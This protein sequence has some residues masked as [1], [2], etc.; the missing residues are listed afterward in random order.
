MFLASSEN[1]KVQA[2]LKSTGL[3]FNIAKKPLFVGTKN[4]DGIIEYGDSPYF[5]L[6]NE[7]SG[8]VI[9]SVKSGYTVTQNEEI[10]SMVVEGIKQFGELSVT[11]GGSLNDGRRVYLQLAIEGDSIMG[12]G[13]RIKRYI[14]IIDSNDGSTGLSVGIGNLT[15]SCQNQFFKFYKEG[16]SKFRHTASITQRVKEIPMLIHLALSQ[17]IQTVDLYKRFAEVKCSREETHRMVNA[18][19]GFDKK[20]MTKIEYAD[21]SSRNENAMNAFYDHLHKEMNDKGNNVWG[22]FSGVTSWTTHEKSAPRRENGRIE[23]AMIG[24]NYRT[25]QEGLE[26]AKSL[27]F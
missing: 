25:N 24:T 10:V 5:A 15:M 4:D 19:L 3:D 26:F 8:N 20:T 17:S 18:M 14:T 7:R 22:L 21:L 1:Q 6:V 12:D 13:D 27:V 2:I 16:Q 23:S 9:N 11:N